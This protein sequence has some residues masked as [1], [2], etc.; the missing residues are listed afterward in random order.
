MDFDQHKTKAKKDY[1][2]MESNLTQKAKREYEAQ[3]EK[4]EKM[5]AELR[6][7]ANSDKEFLQMEL[8]RRIQELEQ[9][10]VDLKAGFA[11]EK[12]ELMDQ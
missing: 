4:Y 8:Q 6:N 3:K 9:Q 2:E 5:L 12:Q 10:I 1:D 7:N 11:T